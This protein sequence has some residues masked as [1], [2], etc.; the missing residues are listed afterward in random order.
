MGFLFAPFIS[1]A[2]VV[3][4]FL[5]A[6]FRMIKKIAFNFYFSASLLGVSFYIY[7]LSCCS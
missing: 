7:F 6:Y 4:L 2:I 3:S 1:A 5:L